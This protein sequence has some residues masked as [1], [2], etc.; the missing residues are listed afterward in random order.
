[1]SAKSVPLFGR[2][3]PGGFLLWTAQNA[4]SA[5]L[6]RADVCPL[7]DASADG[8]QRV[9]VRER[10]I[11]G[12]AARMDDFFASAASPVLARP[13]TKGLAFAN[14]LIIGAPGRI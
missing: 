11:E 7:P 8:L 13:K 9:S 2:P 14:P 12:E 5:T 3:S 1:M 4:L 10:P 6:A